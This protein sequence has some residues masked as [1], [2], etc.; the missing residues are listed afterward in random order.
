MKRLIISLFAALMLIVPVRAQMQSGMWEIFPSYG[1]PTK[2]IDTPEY[3]YMLT[4]MSLIGVDKQTNELIVFNTGHR[5]NSNQVSNIWYSK[6]GKF[7]FVVHSNGMIDLLYDDGRTVNIADLTNSTVDVGTFNDV[8][9]RDGKAYAALS[10][11]LLVVDTNR[12]V[13]DQVGI[14]NENMARIA[15]TDSKVI[16]AYASNGRLLTADRKGNL[17]SYSSFRATSNYIYRSNNTTLGDM[18]GLPGDK[19]ISV[20]SAVNNQNLSITTVDPTKANNICL[21]QPIQL[22]RASYFNRLNPTKDGFMGTYSTYVVYVNDNGEITKTVNHNIPSLN[23]TTTAVANWDS[24][25][26]DTLWFAD[27]NGIGLRNNDGTFSL[28]QMRPAAISGTNIG[29]FVPTTDGQIYLASVGYDMQTGAELQTA[30]STCRVDLL[31]ENGSTVAGPTSTRLFEVAA[32]PRNPDEIVMATRAGITRYNMQ[33]KTATEYTMSNSS[34]SNDIYPTIMFVVSITFDDEGNLWALQCVSG[35]TNHL[36]HFV[37]AADW[38]NGA[39]KDSWKPISLGN[40]P[41]WYGSRMN[42]IPDGPGYIIFSGQTMLGCLDLNGTRSN[43]SDDTLKTIEWSNDEDGMTLGGYQSLAMVPDKQGW[44][45]VAYDAGVM[46][47]RDIKKFFTNSPEPMRPKVSRNDGTSLADYLLNNVNV[48]DICVDANNHKWLATIGSGLY[49]VNEDG[50]EILDH[51][52]TDTS[53][54]PSDNVLAVYA[55]PNS[56]KVYVGTDQGLVIYHALSSPAKHDFKDVY[57]FPNPVTPDYT[58][59]ITIAGLMSNSLVKITDSAGRVVHEGKSDGG[60]I[61]W[62]GCDINGSRVK[63]GVYFVYASQNSNGSSAAVTKIVV[64]N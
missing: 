58:G 15:V 43:F 5:L 37:S 10:K 1:N 33:T 38:A 46:V 55:D 23:N 48:Y 27:A 24:N 36:L 29:Q 4:N 57:A 32:N 30:S 6:E 59:H 51:F 64:V 3:V 41:I 18:W 25:N 35:G 19:F 53:D 28:S 52:T 11:G 39:P 2:L 50:T 13:I 40:I 45:W 42:F 7:L 14:F 56:N 61:V 8:D 34:L 17:S 47:Y 62:D 31:K 49:R 16:L 20:G 63:S 54:L 60:S 12:G 21:S 44:I 26:E 22:G 9:F